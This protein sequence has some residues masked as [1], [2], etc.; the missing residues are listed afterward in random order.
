MDKLKQI[1]AFP[2][3]VLIRF[4]Q[5]ALSPYLGGSKSNAGQVEDTAMTQCHRS[6]ESYYK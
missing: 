6:V 1:I 4:Y 5:Y 3:I 2:F